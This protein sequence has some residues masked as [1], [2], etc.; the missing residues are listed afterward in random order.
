MGNVVFVLT[1]VGFWAIVFVLVVFLIRIS[2]VPHSDDQ[3]AVGTTEEYYSDRE[4]RD[5]TGALT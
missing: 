3:E 2:L 4:T 1:V 5:N